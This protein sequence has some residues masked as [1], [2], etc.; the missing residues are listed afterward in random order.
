MFKR[1][2]F[3][4]TLLS[5]MLS[6]PCWAQRIEFT[7]FVGYQ[8][9]GSLNVREGELNINDSEN[10]GFT[11]DFDIRSDI[12][13]EALYIRQQ[14]DL[15]L[16]E[17]PLGVTRKLFDMDVEYYQ[18]GILY[19]TSYGKIR[20]FAAL[21]VGVTEFDPKS[22]L[23]DNEWLA[24]ATIGGGLKV[25]LSRSLGLRLQGRL[26]LPFNFVGGTLFCGT[27]G[28][29]VGLTGGAAIAQVDMNAGVTIYF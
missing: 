14:T 26:L 2:L 6:S 9:F 4:F 11:L 10:F 28:C 19:E 22:N 23:Y 17:Q 29:G 12:K 25:R 5:I 3:V 24:S 13:I 7:P 15:E 27:G 18:L 21:T 20:P 16:K 8:F 1:H